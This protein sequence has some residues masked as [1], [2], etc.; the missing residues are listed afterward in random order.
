MKKQIKDAH[1]HTP[2][3]LRLNLLKA[4]MTGDMYIPNKNINIKYTI[5]NLQP[6]PISRDHN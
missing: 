4:R 5:K 3:M 6:N 2:T 1:S